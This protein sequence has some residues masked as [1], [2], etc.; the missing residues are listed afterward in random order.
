MEARIVS[1]IGRETTLLAGTE[2]LHDLRAPDHRREGGPPSRR[3]SD[4]RSKDQLFLAFPLLGVGSD[5]LVGGADERR[6]RENRSPSRGKRE[7]ATPNPRTRYS[8]TQDDTSKYP[9][10]LPAVDGAAHSPTASTYPTVVPNPPVPSPV[11]GGTETISYRTL[12]GDSRGSCGSGHC[13]R[14]RG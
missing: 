13:G 5:A 6:G 10:R 14:A 9:N 8:L 11:P 1:D 12:R 4:E 3:R 2:G 7:P